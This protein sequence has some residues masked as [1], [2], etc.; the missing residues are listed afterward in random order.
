M[1]QTELNCVLKLN[2][3]VWNR[4]DFDIETLFTLNW[5]VWKRT[6]L[7]FTCELTKTI[8]MQNWIVWIRTVRLN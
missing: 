5:I 8:L 2:R 1:G 6:V 4:T 3:I 7:T